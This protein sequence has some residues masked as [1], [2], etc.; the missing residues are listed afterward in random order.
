MKRSLSRRHSEAT[1]VRP[2]LSLIATAMLLWTPALLLATSFQ[3]L[4]QRLPPSTNAL[5]AVNVERILASSYAA[6][7]QWQGTMA[8]N[9]AKRP[10]IVPPGV[11]RLVMGAEF[12]PSKADAAWEVTLMDMKQMP[13]TDDLCK[14]EGGHVDRIWDKTAVASPINAYFIPLNDTILA[15]C[16]PGERSTIARWVRQP[17]KDGGVITSPYINTV[18]DGLTDDTDGVMAMDL[19]GAFGLPNIRRFLDESDI[20]ELKGK[21]LDKIAGTLSTLKGLTLQF[22]I[23]RDID[24]T[25]VIG[26]DADMAELS[27]AAKPL[28]ISVLNRAGMRIDD[29]DSWKFTTGGKEIRA[30]G[31]LSDE[32]FRKLLGVVQS[33]VPAIVSTA[34]KEQEAAP[35]D[36][37]VASQRYFKSI[38]LIIDDLRA[39]SSASETATWWYQKAKRIDTLPILHVD[40]ALV[41]WG[42]SVSTR[43][44]QLAGTGAAGQTQI[45]ARVAGVQS[46]EYGHYDTNGNYYW[47]SHDAAA[48]ENFKRQ[49]RQAA[50]EQKTQVQQQAMLILN[51]AAGSRQKIRAEMTAKYK[52]EF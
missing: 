40:P 33:P 23:D 41:E 52:V 10:Q 45:Q 5:V 18:L 7:Q 11:N 27:D 38:S 20:E 8:E 22:K 9:W 31:K 34:T 3:T 48:L 42:A 46:P 13:S 39:G 28:L 2:A 6:Q 29:I 1:P 4:S 35:A 14:A 43:L 50:L 15:V 37:A 30:T 24:A 19:E 32:S 47:A 51:E 25:T 36:P 26:F 21:N 17:V 49:R 44:K 16:T 12:I